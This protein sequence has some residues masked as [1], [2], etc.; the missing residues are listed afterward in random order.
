L[1]QQV[2]ENCLESYTHQNVAFNE[3]VNHLNVER[4]PGIN[5]I[6]QV[7]LVWQDWYED[8][9]NPVDG[10]LVRAKQVDSHTAKFDLTFELMPTE[11]GLEGSIEYNTTLFC[12]DTIENLSYEFVNILEQWYQFSRTFSF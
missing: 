1:L 7:M 8:V 2:K 6:F 5:P 3:L 11:L 10:M 12:S 4:I 9:M